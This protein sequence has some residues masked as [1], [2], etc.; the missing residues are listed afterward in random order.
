MHITDYLAKPNKSIASPDEEEALGE[1]LEICGSANT[2]LLQL[3]RASVISEKEIDDLVDEIERLQ[4]LHHEEVLKLK[5]RPI[6]ASGRD[7]LRPAQL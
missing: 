7:L 5:D 1:I 3:Y 2:A 4:K 6:D